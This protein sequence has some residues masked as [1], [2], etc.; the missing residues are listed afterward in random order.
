VREKFCKGK[1]RTVWVILYRRQ[2]DIARSN[3][4]IDGIVDGVGHAYEILRGELF[5]GGLR[6]AVHLWKPRLFD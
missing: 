2:V 4:Y 5:E 6:P 1:L 3:E